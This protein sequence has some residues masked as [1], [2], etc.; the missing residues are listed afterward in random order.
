M[1]LSALRMSGER[2]V[3]FQ[4]AL[5]AAELVRVI[6]LLRGADFVED[7]LAGEEDLAAGAL[8]RDEA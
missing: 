6:R 5:D 2:Q 7:L 8:A 3:L 4:Q 1:V